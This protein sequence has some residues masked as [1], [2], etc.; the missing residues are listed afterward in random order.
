M[1]EKDIFLEVS[2]GTGSIM[3]KRHDGSH[4]KLGEIIQLECGFWHRWFE[5]DV[6]AEPAWIMR[7][8]A[9]RLDEL[10]QPWSDYLDRNLD[11]PTD[12]MEPLPSSLSGKR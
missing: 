12:E 6:G 11:K 3:V 10:N 4:Q 2:G 5:G 8:I 7:A 9:D 1:N